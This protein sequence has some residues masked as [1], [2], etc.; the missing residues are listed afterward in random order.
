MKHPFVEESGSQYSPISESILGIAILHPANEQFIL[1][2]GLRHRSQLHSIADEKEC[3]NGKEHDIHKLG[4]VVCCPIC[5]H[6]GQVCY[7]CYCLGNCHQA[8]Q[9]M[10]DYYALIPRPAVVL[11]RAKLLP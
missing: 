2:K 8:L 5:D 1:A 10:D 6:V 11:G 9:G 3:N 4:M 7:Q